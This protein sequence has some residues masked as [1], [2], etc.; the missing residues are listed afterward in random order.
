[1]LLTNQMHRRVL[2]NSL[3][4]SGIH[5]AQHRLLMTLSKQSFSS[6]VELAKQLEVS[7]ATI[8]VSLKTLK[9]EGLIRQEI[10]EE[11]N[12]RNFIELT[13]EG[14]KLV[15]ESC[16]FFDALDQQMYQGFTE[17]EKHNLCDYLER[18]YQNMER[19]MGKNKIGGKQCNNIKNM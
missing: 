8:A 5:R 9:K 2:D 15:E 11:D 3:D 19:M 4:G 16:E 12:R 6:Q 1:M 18:I 17:E 7:A 10:R 14:R 13:D